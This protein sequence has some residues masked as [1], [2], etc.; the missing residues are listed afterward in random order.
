MEL[1]K[2][3]LAILPFSLLM[4]SDKWRLNSQWRS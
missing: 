2:T 4:I 1:V 3:P